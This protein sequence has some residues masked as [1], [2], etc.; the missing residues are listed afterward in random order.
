MLRYCHFVLRHI[1][2][3]NWL[4]L[5]QQKFDSR[6]LREEFVLNLPISP[7]FYNH[8]KHQKIIFFSDIFRRYKTVIFERNGLY[9]VRIWLEKYFQE[10]YWSFTKIWLEIASDWVLSI[11]RNRKPK[12]PHWKGGMT[13]I[14][15][16]FHRSFLLRTCW[17][18]LSD[19]NLKTFSKISQIPHCNLWCLC[20]SNSPLKNTHRHQ[21]SILLMIVM[22]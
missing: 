13:S 11:S 7:N 6:N 22:P 8:W 12:V 3:V 19:S 2:A 5:V 1:V 21:W 15:V 17:I 10:K 9:I 16:S 4:Y 18:F 20:C 14:T